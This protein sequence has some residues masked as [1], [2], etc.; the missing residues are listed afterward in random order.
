MNFIDPV[1]SPR[2]LDKVAHICK[3]GT[4]NIQLLNDVHNDLYMISVLKVEPFMIDY[5]RL[6]VN[7]FFQRPFSHAA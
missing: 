3:Y 4:H 5:K 2:Y 6:T 7:H 1:E